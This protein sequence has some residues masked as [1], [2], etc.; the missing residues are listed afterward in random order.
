MTENATNQNE[1]TILDHLRF[2]KTFITRFDQTELPLLISFLDRALIAGQRFQ[3]RVIIRRCFELLSTLFS[4]DSNN[5][6]RQD[7]HRGQRT[8]PSK[9]KEVSQSMRQVRDNAGKDNEC[10]DNSPGWN[11]SAEEDQHNGRCKDASHD[12]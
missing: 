2:C 7:E 8:G 4:S 1:A 10:Q 3:S 5:D 11:F 6:E 9:L 12:D